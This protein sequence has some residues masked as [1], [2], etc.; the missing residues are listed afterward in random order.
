MTKILDAKEA[1]SILDEVI[2]RREDADKTFQTMETQVRRV[3]MVGTF[4]GDGPE[5]IRNHFK[6]VQL[7]TI[8][9]FRGFFN[10][11]TK[12][13]KQ[14]KK[15]IL[16]FES[17]DALVRRDFW[18]MQVPKGLD[19]LMLST[20][21]SISN[22][23]KIAA[24]IQ[25]IINIGSLN[26][27]A[28][29]MDIKEA[30]RHAQQ[31][32]QKL[33]SLDKTN[34]AIM[35][36]VEAHLNSL[37]STVKK[38]ERWSS[39]G[40]VMSPI[41]V[42]QAQVHF[43]ENKLHE[44]AP[45]LDADLEACTKEDTLQDAEGVE[46]VKNPAHKNAFEK[47]IDS[48]IEIGTLMW[49]GAE[50]RSEK[51]F[52]SFYD[53]GNYV[54][55]GLY[56]VGV[57][58]WDGAQMRYNE[59]IDDPSLVSGLNYA[60]AGMYETVEGAVNPEDPF[61]ADHW[62][63]SFALAGFVAGGAG[64]VTRG[65]TNSI[66]PGPRS[67]GNVNSVKGSEKAADAREVAIRADHSTKIDHK[68]RQVETEHL[69][70][71]MSSTFKHG[72]YRTVVATEDITLYRAFGGKARA[73]GSFTTT[74]PAGNRIQTKMDLAL[75]PEWKNSRTYES[76]IVVPKGTRMNIGRAEKQYNRVGTVFHGDGDQ[77]VLPRDFPK[78]WIKEIRSIPSR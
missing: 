51:A 46:M 37:G 32:H 67:A 34:T 43:K 13:V 2:K 73:H 29:T 50:G 45:K 30:K 1:I 41:H 11:Y 24:S 28:M 6:Y 76:V 7:P 64:V 58:M 12:A 4:S 10:V 8:R 36:A 26:G 49:D 35:K 68:V 74:T 57:S 38:A 23:N 55:F 19:R 40:P 54:T 33:S 42:R 3:I 62:L 20:N 48:F 52:D 17:S 59:F 72:Q 63:N 31:V 69:N 5:A 78:E 9:S 14:M 22:V 16:S 65:A 77:I 56:D 71:N 27:T 47:S 53:Y 44:W 21:Q 39:A 15:N 25:D 66:K 75:K 61:S 70:L 60:S 18:L